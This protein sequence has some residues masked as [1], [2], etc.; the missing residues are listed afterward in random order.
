M[1]SAGE[2]IEEVLSLIE[3]LAIGAIIGGAVYLYY[4]L[5]LSFVTTAISQTF[6]GVFE[7]IPETFVTSVTGIFEGFF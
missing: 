2:D 7:I 5:D 3:L 4:K 6:K 1:S